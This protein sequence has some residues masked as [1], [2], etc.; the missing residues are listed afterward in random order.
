VVA[1]AVLSIG[2]LNETVANLL[3]INATQ[4]NYTKTDESTVT[5]DTYLADI[6]SDIQA[7][8]DHLSQSALTIEKVDAA[9][10]YV[11]I[12]KLHTLHHC[13][14]YFPGSRD[15]TTCF[16]YF[17]EFD[18]NHSIESSGVFIKAY[19]SSADIGN[20][21]KI[22]KRNCIT[23]IGNKYS[24]GFTELIGKQYL[25]NSTASTEF[26]CLSNGIQFTKKDS[27]DT[28][29]IP[30]GTDL[31]NLVSRLTILESESGGNSYTPV[32]PDTLNSYTNQ[33][34]YNSLGNNMS[35]Q[36]FDTG[37]AAY[38][39]QENYARALFEI[40]KS[41]NYIQIG[42]LSSNIGNVFI[43][44]KYLELYSDLSF[45]MYLKSTGCATIFSFTENEIKFQNNTHYKEVII[46]YGTDLTNYNKTTF[47]QS[48]IDH[49]LINN[50]NSNLF[51]TITNPTKYPTTMKTLVGE[52]VFPKTTH[53]LLTVYYTSYIE[54]NIPQTTNATRKLLLRYYC[55]NES[56]ELI[57]I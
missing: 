19:F 5:L 24:Y 31:S 1:G 55:L 9:N 49:T 11:G 37:V 43:G 56:Y 6:V 57:A 10:P 4:V 21:F 15:D 47:H 38:T 3:P 36:Y 44:G 53:T 28:V 51:Q 20:V 42:T 40:N 13:Y 14:T 32:I 50:P 30:Y 52:D 29:I 35:F 41:N 39:K 16:E 25:T 34:V 46:P 54:T 23:E 27:S 33:R 17:K 7:T 48:I 8:S 18:H 22:D 12:S 45:T 2:A 26:S